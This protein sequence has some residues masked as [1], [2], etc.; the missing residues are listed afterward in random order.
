[1]FDIDHFKKVND[2]RGHAAGDAVLTAMG[3]LL[4]RVAR[5]TDVSCRWGGE[6]VVML[7]HHC[8]LNGGVVA[9]ER[10]RKEVA[11]CPISDSDGERVA[12]TA[13][14]GVAEFKGDDTIDTLIDRADHAMYEAKTSGRNRVVPKIEE[15][16]A[17]LLWEASG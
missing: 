9:A 6:E 5:Q 8:D 11:Q 12:V 2:E 7:L 14:F 16:D 4:R 13:S 3:E 17:P 10:L 1:L 15:T